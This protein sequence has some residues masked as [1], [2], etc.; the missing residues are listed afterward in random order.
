MIILKQIQIPSKEHDTNLQEVK[1]L[2]AE[3]KKTLII[4]EAK[5]LKIKQL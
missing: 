2:L 4:P 1:K 3:I 5:I